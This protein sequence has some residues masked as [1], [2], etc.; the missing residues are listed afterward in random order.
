MGWTSGWTMTECDKMHAVQ[1]ESQVIGNFLEWLL[2]KQGMVLCS[3]CDEIGLSPMVVNIEELLADYFE[4][5]LNKVEQ[6]K[7]AILDQQRAEN[8]YHTHL[9]ECEQCEQHPFDQ[10][11]IGQRLLDAFGSTIN[12]GVSNG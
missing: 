2:Q 5:D 11:P 9:D 6:E 1:N 7:R 3:Y 4:I 10:C 12:K 8:D